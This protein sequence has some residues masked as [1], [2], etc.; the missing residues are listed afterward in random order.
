MPVQRLVAR[1]RVVEHVRHLALAAVEIGCGGRDGYVER[2][3]RARDG[4]VRHFAIEQ[5][6]GADLDGDNEL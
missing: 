1:E 6:K 4:R 2:V 5:E 3:V